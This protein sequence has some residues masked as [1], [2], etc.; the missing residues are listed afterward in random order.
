MHRS[1]KTAFS[2]DAGGEQLEPA[3]P[4]CFD[5]A[6]LARHHPETPFL[7]CEFLLSLSIREVFGDCAVAVTVHDG[8]MTYVIHYIQGMAYCM[9]NP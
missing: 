2:V 8:C 5:V 4:R 7:S 3:H 1:L 9:L 6:G